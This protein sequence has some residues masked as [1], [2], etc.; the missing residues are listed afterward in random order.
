VSIEL[1]NGPFDVSMSDIGK[2]SADDAVELF[3]QLLVAEAMRT[4]NPVTAIN[5]PKAITTADGG[6]DAE[7]ELIS[8]SLIPGGLLRNGN[9]RYQIKTGSFS[10]SGLGDIKSLVLQPKYKTKRTYKAEYLNPRVKNCLDEAGTFIVVLFGS[11]AVGTTEDYGVKEIINFLKKYD[12]KYENANIQIIRANQLCAAIKAISPALALRLNGLGGAQGTPFETLEFLERSCNLEVS[13]YQQTDELLTV[14]KAITLE[15][16]RLDGF[17]HI[18]VLGDAGAGKTHLVFSSLD[19]S[20]SKAHV[21]YCPE[22]EELDRS[23]AFS[24]LLKLVEKA[25][26]ILV[27]DECDYE[28]ATVLQSRLKRTAT[29]FLLITLY[30]QVKNDD[31]IDSI[32]IVEVPPLSIEAMERIFE[33]YGIPKDRQ[34][35]LADLC[36]GSPRIAHS[37]GQFIN[38]NPESDYATHFPKLD[39][40]WENM[41]C[42]PEGRDSA[43][44]LD[45]LTVARTIAVFRRIAWQG[46]NGDNGKAQLKALLNLIEPGMSSAV[47]AN[48]VRA[49]QQRRILQGRNIL[50]ISPKLLHIKLWSDWWGDFGHLINDEQIRSKLEGRMLE[51]FFEMF[52]Y[53]NESKAASAVV[54]RLLSVEGPLSCLSNFS[55]P[56]NPQLFFAL[57]LGN[58]KAALRRLKQAL[59]NASEKERHEFHLGRRE[60]VH[61]LE[62]L[63]IPALNFIDV[64]E[65]LLLLAETENETWSNNAT[66]VFVSLFTLGYGKLAASQLSPSAKLPYLRDLLLSDKSIRRKLALRA[67]EESLNPFITRIDIGNEAGIRSLPERWMP[68]NYE[69][70]WEAYSQH[71]NLLTEAYGF[72]PQD[73]RNIPANAIIRNVRHLL[74]IPPLAMRI[75]GL[76]GDFSLEN[77]L[78]D[79]V[80]EAVVSTLHYDRNGLLSGVVQSLE[81][82][83]TNL[84]E[85]SFHDKFRRFVG[86]RLLED[87]FDEDGEYNEE[88]HPI[89]KTLCHDVLNSPSLLSAE[90][91]W[92]VTD[93]A[94][95][96]YQFG[97][98]LGASDHSLEIWPK[99]KVAWSQAETTR[100]DFFLGGYLSGVFGRDLNLWEKL[101]DELFASATMAEDVLQLVWRSGMSDPIAWEL[102]AKCESGQIEAHRFRIL[103]YGGIVQK[104]PFEVVKGLVNKLVKGKLPTEANAAL[105]IL[106]SRIRTNSDSES[107]IIDLLEKVLSHPVFISGSEEK[108]GSDTMRDYHW[109][110]G[111]KLL[112]KL[113]PDRAFRIASNCVKSFGAKGSI[114]DNYMAQSFEFF[115]QVLT[116]WPSEFWQ[117]ISFQI[118]PSID[119]SAYKIL[120]WLR[121][122]RNSS[123]SQESNGLE[124]I[125]PEIILDW[126]KEDPNTRAWLLAEYCPPII[127][128]PEEPPT[129]ARLILEQY[130]ARVNVRQSLHAN[131]MT[132]VF[133][134]P[135]SE[136][137][138]ARV[139]SIRERL[140]NETN[141]FVT[142]WFQEEIAQL[143]DR[144][145][146]E[147]DREEL[148]E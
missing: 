140:D 15:T 75:V 46:L 93:Q 108:Y 22:A 135:A 24:Q 18:R 39:S 44:G 123:R 66:G 111:A 101:I 125:P 65:C 61:G 122:R 28:T 70:L 110:K 137:Y 53:A 50:Y 26:V 34:N 71:V 36:H 35:W 52:V 120:Q 33:S 87:D 109:L 107:D 32:Q 2:L 77:A 30:N 117:I 3:H 133:W 11:E 56:G 79:A 127:S 13:R 124:L 57:A 114:T 8:G 58:S 86:Q 88:P 104:L 6:I 78:R 5:V 74:S 113:A 103:V 55:E 49:L 41:V 102:L 25:S 80:I 148:D 45:R 94:K 14:A 118:Q 91:S 142:L 63:A 126:I 47:V 136:Y 43:A 105:D 29:H 89:L 115:D 131:F 19:S 143:I 12:Q 67:L 129:L 128:L 16:D 106:Q 4:K 112:L 9:A 64:A 62:R 98:L 23:S 100:T 99:I 20:T 130:G 132:G 42:S 119:V 84:T 21:L 146:I 83:R 1:S 60:V 51:W 147:I 96:G 37:V 68:Q 141:E 76:L 85:T 144:I 40:I 134:G 116:T 27:A 97:N 95:N 145:Q 72:L 73:E 138:K 7:I 139:N 10:A 54:E 90:L 81:H 92:L 82:L 59:E 31:A 69:E 121:G 48:S 17:R 38:S